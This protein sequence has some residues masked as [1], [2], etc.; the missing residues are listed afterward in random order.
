MIFLYDDIDVTRNLARRVMAVSD[1]SVINTIS[2]LKITEV[3]D[4]WWM[5][6]CFQWFIKLETVILWKT[7]SVSATP[8]T[9][10]NYYIK[11]VV[12]PQIIAFIWYCL[13]FRKMT[14][15]SCKIKYFIPSPS[16]YLANI[17]MPN[18]SFQKDWFLVSYSL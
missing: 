12:R 1:S 14:V 4:R 3:F 17:T 9:V 11:A 8:E 18:I 2:K 13:K 7:L 10:H 16:S 15:H 6:I 5:Y